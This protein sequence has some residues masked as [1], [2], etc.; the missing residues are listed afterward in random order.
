MNFS[1][2]FLIIVTS[3]AALAV[4]GHVVL[5]IESAYRVSEPRA[6]FYSDEAWRDCRAMGDEALRQGHTR[7]TCHKPEWHPPQ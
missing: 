7:W 2:I 3:L 4:I 6:H 1:A 5:K